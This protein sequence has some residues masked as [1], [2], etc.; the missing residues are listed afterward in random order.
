MGDL[1]LACNTES[2]L[3]ITHAEATGFLKQMTGVVRFLVV[4]PH[5]E[6][7]KRNNLKGVKKEEET[8][9]VPAKNE[10]AKAS[11]ARRTS[12]APNSPA[13]KPAAA[14]PAKTPV[15]KVDDGKIEVKLSD[16]RGLGLTVVGGSDTCNKTVHVLDVF[17]D[18]ASAKTAKLQI[19]DKI[20]SINGTVLDTAKYRDV[21][22]MLRKK[23]DKINIV[24]ERP[25]GESSAEE[26]NVELVKK[27]SKGLGLSLAGCAGGKGVYVS[28]LVRICD[29]LNQCH[30]YFY[31]LNNCR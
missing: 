8:L 1:V 30:T 28:Q 11:P 18:G 12:L 20:V 4:N 23:Q 17:K 3:G 7:E 22:R 14:S 21:V 24:I 10:Q 27:G 31:V 9:K 29:A 19:G 26:I 5:D 15:V 25:D 16:G 6:T 13:A 2:F